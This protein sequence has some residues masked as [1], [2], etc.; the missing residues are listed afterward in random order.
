MTAYI[1]ALNKLLET[2]AQNSAVAPNL[3]RRFV[4]WYDSQPEISRC[5]PFAMVELEGALSTQGKYLSPILLSLG[6]RRKR[7]W[8]GGGQYSRYWMP[9]LSTLNATALLA[10]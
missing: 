10:E 1:A 2:A 3:R 9:P 5:R 4:E 6:W 8:T 7:K